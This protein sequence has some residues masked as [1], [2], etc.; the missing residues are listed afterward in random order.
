MQARSIHGPTFESVKT[1][2]EKVM[3][4]ARL[5]DGQGFRPTLAIVFIS[6]KQDRGSLCELLL[7]KNIDILGLTSCGEFTDQHQSEGETAMLLLDL[8]RQ[9]YTILFEEIGD[10]TL[11]DAAESLAQKTNQAFAHPDLILCSSGFNSRGEFLDGESLVTSIKKHLKPDTRFFGGMAGDDKTFEGSFVF[12][13]GRNSNH[14]IMALVVNA[15]KVQ[16]QGTAVI[17]WQKMGIARTVTKSKGNLIYSIDD[18]PAMDMYLKYLGKEEK[19][20]DRDY[21]VLEELSMHYPFIIDRA[22]GETVL[23][24]PLGIDHQ[25]NAMI[26]DVEMPVGT[27]FWFSVPP[28][29]D[30]VDNI[31]DGASHMKEVS[32][33]EAEALLIFSCAGRVNVLGPLTHSENEGLQ[34]IWNT[35]MAGFFTYGE[36][37]PDSSGNREYHSGACCWVALKEKA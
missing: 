14:A 5:P 33:M 2:L 12:T 7:A 30:I 32:A 31:L 22:S 10:G 16:L 21:K 17:G 28:D 8:P 15:D 20:G 3:Q 6:V 19:R 35:P 4:D 36:F 25:E 1:A 9:Y 34:K 13:Q 23:R 26:M 29:F 27:Q 11:S 18:K 24:T 37:G